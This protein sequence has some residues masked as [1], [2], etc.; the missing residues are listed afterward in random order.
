MTTI[1]PAEL[2]ELEGEFFLLTPVSATLD[3][4]EG[5][6]LLAAMQR[7]ND[8]VSKAARALGLHRRSLQRKLRRIGVPP[9]R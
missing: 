4:A 7:Q 6:L 9:R 8:D 5:M 2:I 3:Q 1:T